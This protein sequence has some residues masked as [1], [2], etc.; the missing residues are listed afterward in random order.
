MAKVT[1][2]WRSVKMSAALFPA[3]FA[4]AGGAPAAEAKYASIVIDAESGLVLQEV[5]ADVQNYPAS[6]TKMMTLYLLFEQ[7]NAGTVKLDQQFTVSTHGAAQ[8]PS[9]LNL[10][11]GETISV[12]DAILAVVTKS[13]N[14]IAVT[15]AENLAGSEHAFAERMT[16]KARQLGMRNTFFHNA[17]G[18][19]DRQQHTTARD[20]SLL[21]RALY[22]DFPNY[23]RYFGTHEFVYR[24]MAMQNHNHLMSR[25]PGMD[26]IKTGYIA[27]VGFN[28]AASATRN[29]HRL[30]GVVMGGESARARDQRMALLLN[31]SFARV[32]V[33][34]GA[35]VET[36]A[37]EKPEKMAE[38]AGSPAAAAS[39]GS[40][41]RALAAL[42]PIGRAEAKPASRRPAAAPHGESWAVQIGSYNRHAAAQK[43]ADA[44]AER[45]PGAGPKNIQISSDRRHSYRAALINLNHREALSACRAL[46]RQHQSCTVVSPTGVTVASR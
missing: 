14:D 6:L 26:G 23:Y 16:Q 22:K 30:I 11:P 3:A 21:A 35:A 19:P 9:K 41:V 39:S 29:G 7:L 33:A 1:R 8:A 32:G 17:S 28:L 31:Q 37:A 46:R 5:N 13:A 27:A 42:S 44:A 2:L 45:I 40:A 25:Y 4:I 20:L 24:G 43:A 36:A 34:P 18:L 38:P 12:H 15:I 10:G